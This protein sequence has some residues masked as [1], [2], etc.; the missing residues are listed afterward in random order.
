MKK[1]LHVVM[2]LTA[3]ALLSGCAGAAFNKVS[4]TANRNITIGQE[5]IDLQ[6]AHEK[7][8]INDTEYAQM[9]QDILN[10]A[11]QIGSIN[12]DGTK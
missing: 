1:A 6:A 2:A 5:L 11:T 4:V 9:K 3:V 8:I 10:F 12:L 7:G